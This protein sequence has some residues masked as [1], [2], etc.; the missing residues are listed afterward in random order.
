MKGIEIGKMKGSERSK[1]IDKKTG[2]TID[3]RRKTTLHLY[4]E[5]IIFFW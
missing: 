1:E 4:N 2:K 5:V 3:I